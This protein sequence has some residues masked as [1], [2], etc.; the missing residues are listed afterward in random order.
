MKHG[1]TR[2]AGAVLAA[3][4]LTMTAQACTTETGEEQPVE[5]AEDQPVTMEDIEFVRTPDD[6]FTAL[7]NFPF[8]PHYAQVAG[9]LRIHYVDAG[10]A[11]GPVVV[12]LH[13]EPSWSF[14]YR[15]MIPILADGGY[16]VIAPDLI[17]FGRSDKP[18]D[19]ADHSYERQVGWV[20]E[21][22][23]DHLDLGD[24]TLFAQDW[25]GLIGLRLVAEHGDRFARVAVS[26]TGL[27]VGTGPLSEA[28]ESWV[29]TSQ[30]MPVFPT[31]QI[32]Q[33]ATLSTLSP[34]E[35]AAYDAPFPDASYQAGA[36]VLPALVPVKPDDP[37]VPANRAAWERLREWERPFVTFF[38]DGD[39]IT[40]GGDAAFQSQVPG[41]SGQPH[42]TVTGAGHFLQEDKGEELAHLLID[43]IVTSG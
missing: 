10:P 19:R 33:G 32:L 14:L 36:R 30:T 25:G 6:R 43:F 37:A 20:R 7:P 8:E 29:G 17:G 26:N 41:A 1:T 13:G 21:L 3:T 34:A 27:P 28:F 35:V 22:L 42:T 40:R 39:P 24:V 38:S 16:R 31:G 15:K 9:N 12:L 4:V 11:D 5:T 2:V 18:L 23:F